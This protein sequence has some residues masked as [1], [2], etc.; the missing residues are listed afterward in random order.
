MISLLLK[1]DFDCFR[2]DEKWIE[3]LISRWTYINSNFKIVQNSKQSRLFFDRVTKILCWKIDV[4]LVSFIDCFCNKSSKNWCYE[5]DV[6]MSILRAVEIEANWFNLITNFAF[7]NLQKILWSSTVVIDINRDLIMSRKI[8]ATWIISIIELN[9]LSKN[10][11]N[12]FNNW[13]HF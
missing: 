7:D 10:C 2:N 5:F 6:S 4:E 12:V 8:L 13:L 11:V 1:L 3:E 9:L